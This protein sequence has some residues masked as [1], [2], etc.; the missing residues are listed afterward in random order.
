M[1][2]RF[3]KNHYYFAA[4]LIALALA[5]A[6][7]YY[8]RNEFTSALNKEREELASITELKA[9]QIVNWR[10]ERQGDADSAHRNP[11]TAE[12][13]SRWFAGERASGPRNKVLIWMRSRADSYHYGDVL[14]SDNDGKVSLS[15]SGPVAVQPAEYY[16]NVRQAALSGRVVFGDIYLSE[17][18]GKLHL[19]L[20]IPLT[21]NGKVNGIITYR[22]D[23]YDFLYPLVNSWPIPSKTAETLLVRRE[24]EEVVYITEVR[25]QKGRPLSIRKNISDKD[26]IAAKA[27]RGV[28][29]FVEGVDYRGVSVFAEI[30]N[31]PGSTWYLIGKLDKSEIIQ[32][33]NNEFIPIVIIFALLLLITAL[34][35]ISTERRRSSE[36]LRFKGMLLDSATDAI[37]MHDLKARILY[38]NE[39][40]HKLYGY[41][42]GELLKMR[43]TD[44]DIP[45]EARKVEGR[46]NELVK[47]GESN[48]ETYHLR[49]DGSTFP[50]EV[51]ARTVQSEGGKAILSVVRDISERR[52]IEKMKVDFVDMV[53][54]ELRSPLAIIREALS[55]I[56]DGIRGPVAAEQKTLLQSAVDNIDRLARLTNDILD[57]SKIEEG[58]VRLHKQTV[59]LVELAK[60][61]SANFRS[62]AKEKGLSINERFSDNDVCVFG[63]RDKLNE[64]FTNLISNAVKFT[65]SGYVEVAVTDTGQMAECSVSDT[66]IGIDPEDM[67]KLFHRFEQL[68]SSQRGS[69]LGLVIVKSLVEM[70]G[71]QIRV[72]SEL[73]KGSR[74]TFTIPNQDCKGA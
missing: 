28:T 14:L 27:A 51:H 35:T 10:R 22:A 21:L 34:L 42:Q 45:E 71:G 46:I 3:I 50:A 58:K 6:A 54:H 66:G 31:I 9:G 64:I 7:A 68:A 33:V 47:K 15:L 30:R 44:I 2:K 69:G 8:Y 39:A 53:S 67:K 18:T 32:R 61:V 40:V 17:I 59:S 49:R 74:F 24:G 23:P 56:I 41:S 26:L 25:H 11:F 72:E 55:Q 5:A 38:T 70:H 48:F 62:V 43:I 57:V 29:G 60:E 36:E 4:L 20:M 16:R 65:A 1:F 63:D 13:L 52:R 12:F 73:G 37:F 19:D